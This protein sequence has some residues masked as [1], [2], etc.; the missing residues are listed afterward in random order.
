VT[1]VRERP[2]V[3]VAEDYSDCRDLLRL[4]L[5]HEG[6]DVVVAANGAEAI[7]RA[8]ELLPDLVVMDLSMPVC[9]G[10]DAA[11]ALKGD[12]RTA[13]IP[14]IGHTGHILPERLARARDAGCD[15]FVRKPVRTTAMAEKIRAMLHV[16][17]P[18]P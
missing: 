11:R 5:E 10:V 12:A 13:T 7:T 15:T 4:S 18:K 2:L 8:Q 9:D 17:R 1:S 3:L 14:V 6:F 16:S